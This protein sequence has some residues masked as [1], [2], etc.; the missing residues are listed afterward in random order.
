MTDSSRWNEIQ[1]VFHRL[2]DMPPDVREH[3]LVSEYGNDKALQSQV[4][5][6]LDADARENTA[7]DG[8]LANTA[9]AILGGRPER[10]EIPSI[11]PYIPLRRLGEGGMCVVNI[12]RLEDVGN[13][14]ALKILRVDSVSPARL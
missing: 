3:V 4:R 8:G 2:A 1:R 11:G 13:L 14:V 6:L 5:A 10:R 12:C 7:L 9:H